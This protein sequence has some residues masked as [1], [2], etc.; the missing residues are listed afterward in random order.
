[1]DTIVIISNK[2]EPGVAHLLVG[3]IERLGWAKM[4]NTEE[5]TFR[6]KLKDACYF[7]SPEI[8]WLITLFRFFCIVTSLGSFAVVTGHND[9]WD[10][11]QL[12][13]EDK[14]MALWAGTDYGKTIV[15][16]LTLW[17]GTADWKTV[18]DVLKIWVRTA[19]GKIVVAVLTL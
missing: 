9:P 6:T 11:S 12:S 4:K 1:M 10:H 19:D 16:L 8:S 15:P 2:D 14:G 7:S 5:A 13:Q 3:P 18:L 17:A